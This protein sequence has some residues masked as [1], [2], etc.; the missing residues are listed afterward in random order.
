MFLSGFYG[1]IVLVFGVV[2]LV[3]VFRVV[4]F[5]GLMIVIED[6]ESLFNDN[7][8]ESDILFEFSFVFVLEGYNVEGGGGDDDVMVVGLLFKVDFYNDVVFILF[9]VLF[10]FLYFNDDNN[11]VVYIL[12]LVL[13]LS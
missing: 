6:E 9:F 12:Y 8:D 10:L 3:V 5:V 13:L 2:G 4:I 7:D 1:M 11:L